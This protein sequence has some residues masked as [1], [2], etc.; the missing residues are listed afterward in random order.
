MVAGVVSHCGGDVVVAGESEQADHGVAQRGHD[1]GAAAGSDLRMILCVG[2]IADPVQPIL[3]VPVAAQPVGDVAG[4]GVGGR[5]R[6]DGVDDFGV[7]C[8]VLGVGDGAGQLQHLD[9][10]GEADAAVDLGG[11]Q[12]AF[13][14]AAVAVLDAGVEDRDLFPGEVF[15]L[16]AQRALVVLDGEDVVAAAAGDVVGGAALDSAVRRR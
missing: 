14:G 7:A 10:L 3:D 1:L 15:E 13:G 6:G 16:F 2:D 4:L 12:H 11:L 9:G 5:E 8:A